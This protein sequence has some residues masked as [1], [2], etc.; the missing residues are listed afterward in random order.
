M[1]EQLGENKPH[2]PMWQVWAGLIL[3]A[4]YL[5]LGTLSQLRRSDFGPWVW[6]AN[7]V[8]FLFW[9]GRG[10]LRLRKGRK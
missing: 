8:L 5:T 1:F 2:M 9:S 6:F 3:G 7:G 4:L 10:W